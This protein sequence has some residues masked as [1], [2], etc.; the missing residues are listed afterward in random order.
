MRH[1]IRKALDL[2]LV[3][4]GVVITMDGGV[5]ADVKIALGAVAPTPIRA[6]KAEDVLK[7]NKP[8]DELLEK[9]GL[10]AS[11]EASPRDSMRG[12]SEY[13]KKIIS[14]LVVRA[15]KQASTTIG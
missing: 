9:A 10:T 12:S 8:G 5:F 1:S 7:G 4:V 3:G 14:V 13:K 2:P 6:R 15:I 11:E